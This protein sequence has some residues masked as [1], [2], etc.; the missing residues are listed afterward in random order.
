MNQVALLSIF[1]VTGTVYFLVSIPL[2]F[3]KIRPNRFYGIR[4]P[5]AYESVELWYRVNRLG[6]K[7]F[8][9]YG[10]VMVAIGAVAWLVSLRVSLKFTPLLIGNLLLTLVSFTHVLVACNRVN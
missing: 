5:K 8:L 4:I 10:V 3:D 1:F 6:A 2:L 9:A 7:V